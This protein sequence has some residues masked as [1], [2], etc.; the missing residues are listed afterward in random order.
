MGDEP[1]NIYWSHND[2]RIDINIYRINIA[3]MKTDDGVTSQLTISRTDRQDS[4]KYRCIAENPYGKSEQL[5]FL[6]V[7]GK[8]PP[9]I[10]CVV[11]VSV[12][13]LTF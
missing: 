3:E 5:I 10:L 1:L 8:S 2:H 11:L 12:I 13:L 4:G 7:Q 6:A 9:K